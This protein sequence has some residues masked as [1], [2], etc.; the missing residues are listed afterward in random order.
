LDFIASNLTEV[1]NAY[2]LSLMAYALTQGE[3]PAADSAMEQLLSMA[4][5]DK[6]GLYWQPHSIEAASY[7][8]LS[9]LKQQRPESQPALEWLSAQR[10]SLGGYG[11]TQD[12]V[13]AF[14][15]L[16]AA[17]IQQ[18]RNLDTEIDVI[19]DG[20]AAHTF[21]V[22][23]DNF[24]I[25]QFVNVAPTKTITLEQRGEG[26]VLYQ[27]A[28]SYNVPGTETPVDAPPI[29]LDVNYNAEHIEVDDV[30]DVYVSVMYAGGQ[31]EAGMSIVDVSIPTGFEAVADSIDELRAMENFKRIEIAGR[32]VIFY[33]DTL[34]TGEPFDF[35]F[36]VL[37]KYP[38]KADQ[39]V[40]QAYLY[41][42]RD[43]IAESQGRELVIE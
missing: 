14:K 17:A 26:S 8:I 33:L 23:A 32:K 16:T 25:M 39:G 18:S 12:T 31:N 11:A 4:Q 2:L 9:L 37:A 27:G 28:Y 41:Y 15:A 38:V 19:V 42:D 43:V 10:N 35:R 34:V 40:S 24:D 22:N 6:D 36:K 20:E 5:S 21:D 30:V 29:T 3:H 13:V 1:K 7:A